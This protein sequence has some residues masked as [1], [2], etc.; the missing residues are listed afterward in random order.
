MDIISSRPPTN[1]IKVVYLKSW[2]WG[3]LCLNMHVTSIDTTAYIHIHF[4][5]ASIMCDFQ[6]NI[7]GAQD[8]F[9]QFKS[10]TGIKKIISFRSWAF[11]TELNTSR[12]LREATKSG[13][14]ARF[15]GNLLSFVATHD[16]D[17]IS[18]GSILGPLTFLEFPAATLLRA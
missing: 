10:L 3:K 12:I 8:K 11:S 16:L 1:K 13:N 15:I 14:R 9:D 7:G 18:I 17:G 5:F 4:A 2:N 6:I